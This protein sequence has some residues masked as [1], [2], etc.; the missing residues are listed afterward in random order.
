[1]VEAAL[2]G[3][4]ETPAPQQQV[5]GPLLV[6]LGRLDPGRRE[7]QDSGVV[8]QLLALQRSGESVGQLAGGAEVSR[9]R[10][11]DGAVGERL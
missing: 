2:P 8:G 10:R 5:E 3:R 6:A 7:R 9:G 11:D 4:V 1:M